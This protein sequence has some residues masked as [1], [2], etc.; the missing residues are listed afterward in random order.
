MV[1]FADEVIIKQKGK[2]T[3][4]KCKNHTFIKLQISYT[5]IAFKRIS[6]KE[7]LEKDSENKGD[8]FHIFIQSALCRIKRE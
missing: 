4:I 7:D 6:I 8:I 3:K 1:F 2:N 5:M